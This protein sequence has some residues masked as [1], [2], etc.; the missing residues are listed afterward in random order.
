M[1]EYSILYSSNVISN[2]N[3]DDDD[4]DKDD[5]DNDVPVAVAVGVVVVVV[6]EGFEFNNSFCSTNNY[7]I[8]IVL[9]SLMARDVYSGRSLISA[10]FCIIFISLLLLTCCCVC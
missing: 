4:D 9:I 1:D 8:R 10:S 3:D 2:N 5:D 7:F 6:V